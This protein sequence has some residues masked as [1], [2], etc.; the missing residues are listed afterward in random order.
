MQQHTDTQP[1]P[2][3]ALARSQRICAAIL[4]ANERRQAAKRFADLRGERF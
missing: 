1:S 2:Q 3:S 4:E